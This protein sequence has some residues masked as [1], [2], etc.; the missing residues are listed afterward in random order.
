MKRSIHSVSVVLHLILSLAGGT[1][2]EALDPFVHLSGAGQSEDADVVPLTFSGTQRW[3]KVFLDL[4]KVEP[5]LLPKDWAKRVV[6]P[7]PPANGSPRTAKEM[8]YL[9]DL[10][11]KRTPE[12]EAAIRK[13]AEF[14]GMR[15]GKYGSMDLLDAAKRPRTAAL[16]D[17]GAKQL[18][19]LLFKLK[20]RF[21]RVRPSILDPR[22]KPVLEVPGHPA[23]PSGHASQAFFIACLLAELD[24]PNREVYLADATAIAKRR[25]IAGFHYP[26]D[27][28]AGALLA[29]QVLDVLLVQRQFQ[30]LLEKARAEWKPK[31]PPI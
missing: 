23:Y 20:L 16:M 17:A 9:L 13:E 19:P 12:D 30:A 15:F 2:G 6:L 25:E 11:G 26:S 27:T 14:A 22:L 7:L 1:A 18:N 21:D 29:R 10:Q 8:E 24:P 5:R 28:A 4:T 3:A 31:L